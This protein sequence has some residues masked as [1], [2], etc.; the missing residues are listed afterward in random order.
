[1]GHFRAKIAT[2][3]TASLSFVH[4]GPAAATPLGE[5]TNCAYP[6]CTSQ[7]EILE[8]NNV[9]LVSQAELDQYLDELKAIQKV[10][11]VYPQ[12]A[13]EKD[14]T[15][16]RGALRA[17]P[18]SNLRLTARK[19]SAFLPENQR[20]EFQDAYKVMIDSVDDMDVIAFKRLQKGSSDD[21]LAAAIAKVSENYARMIATVD[22]PSSSQ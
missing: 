21:K 1:M 22:K 10:F 16:M 12:M 3:A 4:P 7:I 17:I 13:S 9:N 5:H 6:A 20:K 15:S 18:A 2:V 14:Y 11:D 19:Y 8:A